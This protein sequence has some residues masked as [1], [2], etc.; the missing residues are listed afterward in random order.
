MSTVLPIEEDP[1]YEIYTASSGQVSFAIPFPFQAEEDVSVSSYATGEWISIDSGFTITGA[2]AAAGGTVTFDAGRTSG[3]KILVAGSAVI[4]RLASIVRDGKFASKLIDDDLD[5]L[6]IIA[7]ELARDLD[8]AIK[9]EPGGQG[10]TLDPA[11]EDGQTL[12]KMGDRL[13]PGPDAAQIASAEGYADEAN[14][15]AQLAKLFE[16]I[17]FDDPAALLAD[18]R[19]SYTEGDENTIVVDVGDIVGLRNSIYSY[20]VVAA[21][22]VLHSGY[23]IATTGGVRLRVEK[24]KN[25]YEVD[26]FGPPRDGVSSDWNYIRAAVNACSADGGGTVQLSDGLYMLEPG[27]IDVYSNVKIAGNGKNR[28]TL[29]ALAGTY[30]VAPF[31]GNTIDKFTLAD[32]T[33]DMGD[34]SYESTYP[35]VSLVSS[36]ECVIADCLFENC[37]PYTVLM[38]GVNR[39][40]VKDSTFRAATARTANSEGV[41]IQS[42][43]GQE[44]RNNRIINSRFLNI[45]INVNQYYGAI[46]GNQFDGW[47]Y[48]GGITLENSEYSGAVTVEHNTLTSSGVELDEAGIACIGIEVWGNY[49]QVLG[50]HIAFAAGPGIMFGGQYTLVANNTIDS[51]C[52][53]F[54]DG[55][56]DA[57]LIFNGGIVARYIDEDT[58]ASYSKIIGNHMFDRQGTKTQGYGYLEE[59]SNLNYIAY[60]DN[61]CLGNRIAPV[62]FQAGRSDRSLPKIFG[63]ST[64]EPGTLAAGASTGLSFSVPG[65]RLGDIVTVDFSL[66][67]L[68]VLLSGYVQSTDTVTVYAFNQQTD[69]RTLGSGTVSVTVQKTPQS[70]T[71]DY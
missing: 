63:N 13:I 38:Q 35:T 41:I 52:Q 54:I 3:E 34:A 66:D 23:H 40:E 57:G 37:T 33:I 45:G 50:N 4:E 60:H 61:T 6:T 30:T 71:A 55:V 19:L 29:K 67:A 51:C 32:L 25:G 62:Y 20:V 36:T 10:L 17:W 46:L 2:G 58:C 56:Q 11:L 59:S 22:A 9:V 16:G 1:R 47:A 64:W 53:Y 69:S 8:L 28:T 12:M 42:S 18:T 26:A 15:A 70:Y 48:G 31:V 39:C 7:Q 44:S 68:G 21:D 43:A 14:K 49:H 27:V 5:R 65:A 24:T